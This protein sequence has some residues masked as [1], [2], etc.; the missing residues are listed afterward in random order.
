[1]DAVF[2]FDVSCVMAEPWREAGYECW[3]LDIQHPPAYSTGGITSD[4]QLHRVH[5]DLSRPWMP[6]FRPSFVAA[7]P[8]CDHLAVSGARWFQGKGLRALSRAVNLFATAAEFCEWAQCPYLI[9]NPV[10]TI[11]TYWRKPDF[12][13]HPH[14]FTGYCRDDN[15]T[16]RTCLWTGGGFVMPTM[17]QADGLPE[18]DNRIHAAPPGP[19]RHNFRSM[20][21]RGFSRAVFE[22]NGRVLT[23]C[24]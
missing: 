13:F 4:G 3:C 2:L 24:P 19:N 17:F 15:Y 5:W 7:F 16:K 8:P 9:E 21:P 10:S 18:P 14:Q 23:P 1:M 22:A 12:T 6:S 11:A 20:T